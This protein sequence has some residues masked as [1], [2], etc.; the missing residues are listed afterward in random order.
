M[1]ELFKILKNLLGALYTRQSLDREQQDTYQ[2]E[3]R[4][5]EQ[6][7]NSIAS[8]TVFVHI[9]DENDNPPIFQNSF[10]SVNI[11]ENLPSKSFVVGV[12]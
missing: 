2:L 10:Y 8:V 11:K 1:N 6:N 12:S 5:L 7:R 4:I 9:Q 3:V